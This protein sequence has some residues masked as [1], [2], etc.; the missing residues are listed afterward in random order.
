MP[1]NDEEM[2]RLCRELF[3]D[4][5]DADSRGRFAAQAETLAGVGRR[6]VDAL[7]PESEPGGHEALL[8][9]AP[10]AG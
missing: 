1:T 3:G 10:D 2:V 5:L 9:E 8:R 7:A 4:P 6:T